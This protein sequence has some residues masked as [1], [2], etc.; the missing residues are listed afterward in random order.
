QDRLARVDADLGKLAGLEK[1]GGGD[2]AS[3][4]L[5][6]K[7]GKRV[8]DDLGEIVVVAN[9]EGEDA[10]GEGL[11]DQPSEHVL[12]RRHS[13]EEAGQRDVDGDEN[14]GEPAHIAL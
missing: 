2:R 8:V 14:A 12:V 4:C 6:A 11:P 1:L 13:P 10:D 3:A 7:P 5:D 9:D